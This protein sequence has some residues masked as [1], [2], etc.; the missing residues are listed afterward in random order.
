MRQVA[1]DVRKSMESVMPAGQDV[2]L[3]TLFCDLRQA[4][5]E[6]QEIVAIRL[7][8]TVDVV[9]ALERGALASLPPWEE[10]SRIVMDYAEMLGLDA[11]PILRRIH[12]HKVAYD[13]EL[14]I[15]TPDEAPSPPSPP[16][17]DRDTPDDSTPGDR[18]RPSERSPVGFVEEEPGHAPPP[19]WLDKRPS[20][21]GSGPGPDPDPD[22]QSRP[23]NAGR[24][25]ARGARGR[26]RGSG[27]STEAVATRRSRT[28]MF[29]LSRGAMLRVAGVVGVVLVIWLVAA[30]SDRIVSG[31]PGPVRSIF[32]GDGKP[33]SD[34]PQSRK[35]D[36]L[37]GR[38]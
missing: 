32:G 13:A 29:S 21:P 37:P 3:A 36:R 11:R 14:G 27:E 10:T 28:S 20:G 23:H 33:A 38:Y 1:A 4:L 6:P 25:T 31:L 18:A 9:D 12:A 15:I 17:P 34:D 26:S 30:N 7:G 2:E 19:T 35:A 8:T 5:N 22:D 16:V 24:Q